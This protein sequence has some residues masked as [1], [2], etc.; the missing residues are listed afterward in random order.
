MSRFRILSLDGGGSWALIEVKALIDLYS[1]AV[2]GH[3]VLAD[4][5]LVAANS[6]GSIVLGGLLENMPLGQLLDFFQSE[7]R[8][9]SVFVEKLFH[10]PGLEKYSTSDKLLGIKSALPTV[11]NQS[12]AA[13]ATGIRGASG[14]PLHAL[15]VTFDYDTNRGVYFRSA[16]ATRPGYG[17]GAAA[18]VTVAEAVHASTNAPIRYFDK[19]AMLNSLPNRRYWDGGISG[20]N[21]P[22]L[23]GVTEALVLGHSPANLAVLSLGTATAVLPLLPHGAQPTPIYRQANDSG[24]VPDLEKLATAIVDDPPDSATFYAH[25]A[26]GGPPANA[27]PPVDSSIVRMSPLISPVLDE[28]GNFILPS[29]LNGDDFTSLVNLDMDAIGPDDVALILE[30][31]RLW[32]NGSIANQPVRADGKFQPEVGHRTYADARKAW[33]ALKAL[34]GA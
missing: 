9:K 3:E 15:I 26:S 12:L 8:R 32:L 29:G 19:P 1:A 5:D 2:T 4:F 17:T 25:A 6:G 33:L 23:A 27:I 11:A 13:V 28:A 20:N 16:P 34:P 14:Q 31:A 18:T 10:L 24:L 22:V 21:N 7:D 30:L